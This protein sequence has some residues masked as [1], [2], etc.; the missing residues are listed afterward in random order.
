MPTID[1]FPI[2]D[3]ICRHFHELLEAAPGAD[4]RSVPRMNSGLLRGIRPTKANTRLIRQ[5]LR[6]T[7]NDS[8]PLD[9]SLCYILAKSGFNLAFITVLSELALKFYARDL[10]AFYGLARTLGAMLVDER[11]AVRQ[12][13]IEFLRGRAEISG[14]NDLSAE[15][16]FADLSSEL[17][18]FLGHIKLLLPE[19]VGDSIL[20]RDNRKIN[21][22]NN[23]KINELRLELNKTIRAKQRL[24]KALKDKITA[25]NTQLTAL[26]EQV[27]REKK[28][29]QEL[30]AEVK[31][32]R[33]KLAELEE[34]VEQ[35]IDREVERR[36]SSRV[37]SWLVEPQKIAAAA[38]SL[39]GNNEQDIKL[40]AAG[41]LR[42]QERLDLHYGNRRLLR[43]N[44]LELE[45]LRSQIGQAAKE[46][47]NPL[48]ELNAVARELAGE[49]DRIKN[50]LGEPLPKE[51]RLN[52][53][54]KI[55]QAQN[56]TEFNKIHK[57]LAQLAAMDLLNNEAPRLHKLYHD[58]LARLYEKYSPRSAADGPVQLICAW[59]GITGPFVLVVDGYNVILGL[60]E[61]FSGDYE[62]GGR[63]GAAARRH[64]LQIIDKL[65]HNSKCLAEVFFDGEEADRENF[66]HCVRVI[67]SGGGNRDVANRADTA[68]IDYLSS[69]PVN[70]DATRIIITDDRDLQ[71]KA[72]RHQGK[73]MPLAQFASLI[74]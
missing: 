14:D 38:Q 30:A 61:I 62:D 31:S 34:R 1:D 63:P 35:K 23:R 20:C 42:Q 41:L 70:M 53:E 48:P 59:H 56:L 12:L 28:S 9:A 17:E 51:W 45:D 15:L 71:T 22:K 13:G 10:A 4:I 18:P 32:L 8:G 68:I 43:Q 67:F 39:S 65:L 40:R 33:H 36:L 26:K 37:R 16:A 66:S 57:L 73:I 3:F 21:D 5:R 27:G 44:L 29:R 11:Q 2:P 47:L 69:L 52:L 49:I 72:H 54:A 74:D 6:A 24:D 55:N 58:G 46:A 64:L 50:L 60:A 25:K 19:K 7:L